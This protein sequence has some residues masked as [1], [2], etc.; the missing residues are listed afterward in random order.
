MEKTGS[1]HQPLNGDWAW[2]IGIAALA[3]IPTMASAAIGRELPIRECQGE[4]FRPA[5]HELGRFFFSADGTYLV[6]AAR[7]RRNG[8]RR[9]DYDD[10]DVI[11]VWDVKSR[12]L[13]R[14]I[15][16]P[17]P[18]SSL[19]LTPDNKSLVIGASQFLRDGD[20]QPVG[21]K[22][23]RIISAPE[24]K[25]AYA[26]DYDPPKQTALRM[27]MLPDG[28]RF[29][30]GNSKGVRI[31]DLQSQK[32]SALPIADEA[33]ASLAVTN[34]GTRFAVAYRSQ[35]ADIWDATKL[36]VLGRLRLEEG[37]KT[38]GVFISASFSPDG[39]TIAT[40]Y[41]RNGRYPV[42]IWDV[43]TFEKR[44]EWDG[45]NIKGRLSPSR[46]L[47]FSPDSTLLIASTAPD[48]A[49]G[50]HV[51]ILKV[52]TRRP[53]YEFTTSTI[54]GGEGVALSPDGRWLVHHGVDSPLRVW[55]F[56][57]IRSDIN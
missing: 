52:A 22:K 34:D 21:D 16:H 5:G 29:L 4:F 41:L 57:K 26:F 56:Q 23:L 3:L 37:D 7:V 48:E 13:F 30:T 15:S 33:V 42:A 12:K 44:G 40:C 28:K 31:W 17:G 45:F 25:V 6:A 11:D 47:P 19:V 1:R 2:W 43:A 8:G 50:C 54:G 55:D 18:I 9:F 20:L 36:Q 46:T 49:D 51:V 27:A 10:N 38:R 24:W 53:V 14:S 35:V 32:A 39:K